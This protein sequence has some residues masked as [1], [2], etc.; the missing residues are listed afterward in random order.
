M[1]IEKEIKDRIIALQYNLM[2]AE[3]AVERYSIE[4]S[5][6]ELKWVLNEQ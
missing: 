3:Q 5:I 1:R 4:N 6:D 2:Y